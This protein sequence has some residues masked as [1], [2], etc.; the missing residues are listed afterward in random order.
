MAALALPLAGQAAFAAPAPTPSASATA[1]PGNPADPLAA[2]E[3]TL[4]PLLDKVHLLYQNAEAAT[5]Q[6][7]ATATRLAV[8]Q[9]DLAAVNAKLDQQQKVVDAGIDVAAELA[10]AQYRNGNLSAYGELL[11]TQD[12]YQAV[13]LGELLAAAGRSQA[14]FIAQLKTDQAALEELKTQSSAA[15]ADSKVLLAQQDKSKAD[16]AQQLATV[17]QLVSSLT[18]AQ[19][20]ELQQLEK[21]Q[22]DQAQV[23]FLASGALGQGERTPSVA[24]RAAVAFALA[25]LGKP[26][27]WGA[28]G[29]GTF[30]CSGL[31]SQAWLHAGVSIP[32][33]S[34]DQWAGLQHVPLNQLRPG[35][36]VVYYAN[37]EHVALYIGGG[38]VVQAPHT[39]A[40]V[41]VSPIGMAPILGAVRPDPQDT[42]DDQG[43]AWKVPDVLQNLQTLTPIAP[44]LA[45][46]Q[47]LPTV[48]PLPAGA[49][50]VPLVSAPPMGPVV[51]TGQ[52]QSTAPGSPSPSSSASGT[53]PSAPGT[54]PSDSPSGSGTATPGGSASPSGTSTPS[55]SASTPAT[56]SPTGSPT[57]G[58]TATGSPTGCSPTGGSS[59]P[60]TPVTGSPTAGA[61]GSASAAGSNSPSGSAPAATTTPSH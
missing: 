45:T 53:Q 57:G 29:P 25:Q 34:Q 55:E 2:A 35:D 59:A 8:Q 38:L 40:V 31:T 36:L 1:T 30:D 15:L 9:G 21:Q 11:L 61:T 44:G 5:E 48:A 56:G 10:A 42:A 4:G 18:G 17:E 7:N 39:G 27:E 43:G 37:A 58:S 23:A 13:H 50:I 24:G 49:P 47:G 6:Y 54:S 26:Y 12:P 16:I 52:G 20:T 32:R 3:A 33:T 28:T 19:Q 41:R 22:A 51:P 60:S 46:V 14:A